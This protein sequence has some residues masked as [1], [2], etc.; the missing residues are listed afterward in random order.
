M[1]GAGKVISLLAGFV[2]AMVP[3]L[4]AMATLEDGTFMSDSGVVFFISLIAGGAALVVIGIPGLIFLNEIRV[5]G[6]S[7]EV[8]LGL[9]IGVVATALGLVI[10]IRLIGI[11]DV[12]TLLSFGAGGLVLSLL[13]ALTFRGC[14]RLIESFA[15]R[16]HQPRSPSR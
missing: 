12:A 15:V 14:N 13:G 10:Y 2:V 9:I 3:L 1:K 6:L 8:V 5:R 7:P 11:D 16:R 4:V